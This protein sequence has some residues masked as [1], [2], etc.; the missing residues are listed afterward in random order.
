MND[1]VRE[2]LEAALSNVNSEILWARSDFERAKQ[3]AHELDARL[4]EMHKWR[5]AIKDHLDG[6]EEDK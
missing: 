2:L 5:K 6:S 4:G 1:V 3:S